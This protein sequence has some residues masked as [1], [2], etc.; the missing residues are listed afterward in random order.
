MQREAN[1]WSANRGRGPI[2]LI[3]AD[4][5]Y[6]YDRAGHAGYLARDG[7][8][9]MRMVRWPFHHIVAG[10]WT[11]LSFLEQTPTPVRRYHA[12]GGPGG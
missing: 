11:R 2:S 5:E 4:F 7:E 9:A 6:S 1:R 12:H 10:C 8:G 3:V